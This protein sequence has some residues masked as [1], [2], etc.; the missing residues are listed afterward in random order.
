MV[1]VRTVDRDPSLPH[2]III[3]TGRTPAEVAVSC[4]CKRLSI[5]GGYQPMGHVPTGEGSVDAALA[6]YNIPSNH[7]PY[8]CLEFPF[9]PD[10][11][12]GDQKIMEIK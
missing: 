8:V 5:N 11:R 12:Y 2:Q 1:L 6:L 7:N 10:I 3:G 4:N 9:H